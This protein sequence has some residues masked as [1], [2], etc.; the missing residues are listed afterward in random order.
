VGISIFTFL[1]MI[2]SVKGTY[3]NV[4]D[5]IN[6]QLKALIGVLTKDNKSNLIHQI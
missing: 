6:G 5:Y 2:I 4:E 3:D 1:S